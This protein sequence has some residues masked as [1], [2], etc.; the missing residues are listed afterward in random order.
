MAFEII[1]P[2]NLLRRSKHPDQAFSGV[3]REKFGEVKT[4][5]DL[6]RATEH[7]HLSERTLEAMARVVAA[8]KAN[9]ATSAKSDRSV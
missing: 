8:R 4:G 1:G 2:A 7:L 9:A 5:G 3:G 6:L